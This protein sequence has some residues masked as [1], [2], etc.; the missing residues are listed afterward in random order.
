[1]FWEAFLHVLDLP[2]EVF[3]LTV[4][5]DSAVADRLFFFVDFL[6]LEVSSETDKFTDVVASVVSRGADTGDEPFFRP[7][8][9]SVFL[10]SESFFGCFGG[11]EGG[12]HPATCS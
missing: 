8:A 10:D 5:G 2:F 9:E 7:F 6:D 12:I 1:M 3:F 4:G 11:D